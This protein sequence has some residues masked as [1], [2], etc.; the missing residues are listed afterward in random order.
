M[1]VYRERRAEFARRIGA[2][3]AVIPAAVHARRNSDT[4]YVYRQ[5]S[6]FFYLTGLGEP[7]A[8][9]IIAPHREE[10]PYTLFLRKRDRDA[11]IWAGKRVGVEG[12]VEQFGADAA[13]PIDELDE[14][15][16][17]YLAGAETLHYPLGLDEK[18]DRRVLA[19][20]RAARHRV[21]RGG[22]APLTFVDPSV[23]L[24]EMRLRKR[25][26]E[27][28]TMRRAGQI[29]RAGHLAAMRAT[30]PGLH[31]YDIEAVLEYTYRRHGAQAV[32]YPSIVAGGANATTLHYHSNR[33]PLRAGTLL[34]VDSAAELDL[35]ASDVTRTWPVSGIFTPEQRAL[36]EI[37]LAAQKAG[38]EEVRAGRRF[39]AYHEATVRVVTAGLVDLGLLRGNVDELIE[40]EEHKQFYMHNAGHWIGLDVHDAG[41]YH[42]DDAPYRPLE[43]GMV[44]TVEPGIYVHEDLDCD[45]RFKGIGIRIEDDVLCTGGDPEILTPGIPKEID[46][47]E[48]IVGSDAALPAY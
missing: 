27:L 10:A 5:N 6:D 44:M 15:L 3:V 47:L 45:P 30:K 24:H 36:Y 43:P 18:F 19:A 12:A 14:K 22:K 38:I 26:E 48:A 7:E 42:V 39:R 23:A 32:A 21:R 29:T 34:L 16:P 31:E 28:A 41:R 33:D 20:V 2:A 46:E 1:S 8:V 40:K 4:E 35:Y 11:E 37:V 17:E 9:A 25:P 13:F